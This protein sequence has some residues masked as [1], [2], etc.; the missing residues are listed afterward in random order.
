MFIIETRVESV[1]VTTH[2]LT[3]GN[4]NIFMYYSLDLNWFI[5]NFCEIPYLILIFK[6]QLTGNIRCLWEVCKLSKHFGL[7]LC[8]LCIYTLA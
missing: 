5:L 6:C 2:L 3:T 1:M 4:V 7:L 8:P